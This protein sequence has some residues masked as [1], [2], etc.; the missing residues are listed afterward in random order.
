MKTMM[1]LLLLL[2]LNF[3]SGYAQQKPVAVRVETVGRSIGD[4]ENRFDLG[5]PL[6]AYISFYYAIAY[7][8]DGQMRELASLRTKAWMA[9]PGSPDREVDQATRQALLG[10]N[11][12]EVRQYGDSVAAIL[13]LYS[14][15]LYI[16]AWTLYEKGVWQNAGEG[17]GRGLEGARQQADE[18]SAQL[19]GI[20]RRTARLNEVPT[21]PAPFAAYLESHG[22]S[23]TPYLLDK[24][25]D[26]KLVIVGEQHRRRISWELMTELIRD[27]AFAKRVGT[28]FMELPSWKQGVMDR[29]FAAKTMDPEWIREVMRAEQ[30][31]GWWD[32]GEYAFLQ[33]L[34]RIN[35]KLPARKKIRVILV[36]WQAPWDSIRTKEDMAKFDKNGKDR[37]VHMADVVEN[38]ILNSSDPRSSLFI[39]GFGHTFKSFVPGQASTAAG[40]EPARTAGAQLADR[41][42][43]KQVFVVA[44]HVMVMNNAIGGVGYVRDGIFDKA[45]QL[46]G[47]RPVAFDLKDSPFGDEPCDNS[48]PERFDIRMGTF[49]DN[50]DGYLFFGPLKDEGPEMHTYEIFT[51]AFVREI[52][53]RSALL[54]I[55]E[56]FDM[57]VPE[58]TPEKIIRRLKGEAGE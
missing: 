39:V 29:F 4:F 50:Y 37:N 58:L 22:T 16:V 34:W 8:K 46:H 26:H 57:P 42:G 12:A 30:V 25:T 11:I 27:P 52:Q 41:L 56:L 55:G 17:I 23:P 19:I 33:E 38:H 32:G 14:D 36:D 6:K 3:S 13:T 1:L 35:R 43:W 45:F 44:P 53:R 18:R 5:S 54:D 28:V 24:F 31:Y 7:G 15:S 48:D 9:E 2:V 20:V 21:D 51:D 10:R 49:Q 47:N 40:M